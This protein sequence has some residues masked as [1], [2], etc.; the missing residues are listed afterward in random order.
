METMWQ[1]ESKEKTI[2]KEKVLMFLSRNYAVSFC[3]SCDISEN[4]DTLKKT[5]TICLN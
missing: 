2:P 4:S 5:L 1:E 3:I